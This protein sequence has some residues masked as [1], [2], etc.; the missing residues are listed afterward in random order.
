[1]ADRKKKSTKPK[2]G[3]KPRVK[4]SKPPANIGTDLDG[5]VKPPLQLTGCEKVS[6]SQLDLVCWMMRVNGYTG[7][8]IAES[9]Q[10]CENTVTNRCHRV[11]AVLEQDFDLSKMRRS[12]HR[13]A[14]VWLRSVITNLE[15][16]DVPMTIAHGKGMAYYVDKREDAHS[17][18]GVENDELRGLLAKALGLDAKPTGG[19]GKD[20]QRTDKA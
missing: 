17:F 19:G 9:L 6:L 20:Q 12:L 13:L 4:S 5:I 7:A 3:A 10:C 2:R 11:D 8:E 18:D 1:M 15:N 14:P 16:G